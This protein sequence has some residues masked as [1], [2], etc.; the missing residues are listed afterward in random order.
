MTLGAFPSAYWQTILTTCGAIVGIVSLRLNWLNAQKAK[1]EIERIRRE[2]SAEE[3]RIV[4]PTS[5]EIERY[6]R[7]SATATRVG[8]TILLLLIGVSFLTEISVHQMSQHLAQ[9]RAE[10]QEATTELRFMRDRFG[11]LNAAFDAQQRRI[12]EIASQQ[13]ELQRALASATSQADALKDRLAEASALTTQQE[14]VIADLQQRIAT[15]QPPGPK[16]KPVTP[17]PNPK[18]IA[19]EDARRALLSEATGL[20]EPDVRDVLKELGRPDTDAPKE[21]LLDFIRKAPTK[22]LKQLNELLR[23]YR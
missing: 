23:K 2:M 21:A 3:R 6:G 9:S 14:Q 8:I 18:P 19:P 7:S 13:A 20:P 1:A 22:D 11:S 16:P 4:T 17:G 12:A 10:Q 5:E 15:M